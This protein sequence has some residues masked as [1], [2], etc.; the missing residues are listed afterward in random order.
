MRNNLVLILSLLAVNHYYVS[1]QS[2]YPEETTPLHIE[3]MHTTSEHLPE[4]LTPYIGD[5][6]G[7]KITQIS[8]DTKFKQYPD[9]SGD[10]NLT[11]PYSTVQAWNSDGTLL[12]LYGNGENTY[13]LNGHTFDTIKGPVPSLKHWMNTNSSKTHDFIGT[14][15]R[16][17]DISAT[18]PVHEVVW[19]TVDFSS[20]KIYKEIKLGGGEGYFDNDDK[21]CVLHAYREGQNDLDII[22]V[23]LFDREKLYSNPKQD[24]IV[25]KIENVGEENINNG[26]STL[27][28]A[29]ISPSGN[30]IVINKQGSDVGIKTYRNNNGIIDLNSEIELSNYTGHSDIAVDADG[31]E[32]LFMEYNHEY[33]SYRLEDGFPY[34]YGKRLTNT[35]VPEGYHN[36]GHVSGRN[37]HRPGWVYVS[38]NPVANLSDDNVYALQGEIFAIKLDYERDNKMIVERYAKHYSKKTGEFE[39]DYKSQPKATPSRDGTKVLFTSNMFN[40]VA[41]EKAKPYDYIVE[42]GA[43]FNENFSDSLGDISGLD[44]EDFFTSENAK[45]YPGH[46]NDDDKTDLFVA[47]GKVRALYLAKASG[48]G[49]ERV[50]LEVN[51]EGKGESGISGEVFF[52][53]SYPKVYLGDYNGDNKTDLFRLYSII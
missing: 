50:I 2:M 49:F 40:T 8:S 45:V 32:V 51:N 17:C 38:G 42:K 21:Y 41:V 34:V 18:Y 25:G 47:K 9:D 16:V 36:G 31:K 3:Y 26:S 22:D 15:Y 20:T 11:H 28:W 23:L 4:Y 30:Y 39:K 44:V 37:I 19:N 6:F 46:Y 12:Q 27:G 7:N 53:S 35:G 1:S 14:Q 29:K 52:S 48:E 13:I 10:N 33:I 5:V 24:P 43:F